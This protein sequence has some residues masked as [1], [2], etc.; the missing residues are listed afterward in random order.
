MEII[1]AK[2]SGF[3][4]GVKNALEQTYSAG[5]GSVTFGE[6]IHNKGVVEDLES[7]GIHAVNSVEECIG[8]KVIIRSHGVG[9]SMQ[10]ELADKAQE[11][12]DAT[13][14]FVKRIHDIVEK[15]YLMGYSIVIV[16]E[17]DHP[18]VIGTNGWC[19]DSA[20][21]ISD[22]SE[23]V[24]L[25]ENCVQPLCVVTQT[26]FSNAK[27]KNIELIIKNYNK[28]VEIFDTICYTT[29]DRQKEAAELAKKCDTV[30]VLGS[31]NSS[32]TRKLYEICKYY[33][34]RTY[35]ITNI[36]DL[37]QVAKNIQRLGITAGAS[38]P[39]ELI[40]EVVNTMSESQKINNEMTEF[41]Q[42]FE[43]SEDVV[44][45]ENKQYEVNV[46]SADETGIKCSF[47]GKKDAFIAKSEV[48]LD[49]ADY[50]PENYPAGMSFFAVVVKN[51]DKKAD[52]ISMSKRIIDKRIEE[53]K[54]CEEILTGTEFTVKI[55]KAVKGG[56]I[57]KLGSYTIFVPQSHVRM[58]FENNL[59]KYV[60]KEMRLCMIPGKS[61]LNPD[62]TE[63]EET[64][65][66]KIGKRVVASHRVI[67]EAEKQAKEDIFW[68]TMEVGGI[69]KG[70]VKRFTTFGAFV[71]VN[72]TDCL[73]HISDLS[74]VKVENPGDVLELNKTY[75]FLVLNADRESG[76]VSLGYK[77][78]QKKPYEEAQEKYP[79]GTIV[80]G[81]I[82]RI[83]NYG[84]FV[85]IDKGIDGL[86]PVS[87]ISY[88][89]VR[90]ANEAFAQGQEV[91]T[92]VI[93]FEGNKIT[94]SIKALLEPPVQQSIA[95][96]VITDDDMREANAQ[97]AKAN[98]KRFENAGGNQANKRNRTN[99]KIE[100][101][102]EVKQWTTET[103]N[104]TFADLF[105][106]LVFEVSDKEEVTDN[107]V[108]VDKE[109]VTAQE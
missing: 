54:K 23:A 81:T 29:R 57:A 14:P 42:L 30:L 78:L 33:C 87:E 75:D 51:S 6:L 91:E 84:A 18:E 106:N 45:K 98:I 83:F 69:V 95:D 66:K 65:E 107:E 24:Q 64:G 16:G 38:T 96:V 86:I 82:E 10:A 47:G 31:E 71:C 80:K 53:D 67:I 8:R 55:D 28:I 20:I 3:C 5:C 13:C 79:I 48:E 60:G 1:V 46:L 52:M 32:N 34:S 92:K 88:S 94:L 105:K 85:T 11:I 40:E 43:Q 39:G 37:S 93:K 15:Y 19:N 70:K 109:E 35:L 62:G 59:E 9:K 50:K 108:I 41:A 77:Q 7:K 26:T 58:G 76:K 2:S 49:E 72:G 56:L 44:I 97:R 63:V 17:K 89:Y 68:S 21:I 101:K 22:E 104:A 25:L 4:F 73:A 27:F 90:D 12:I 74:W 61:E 100:V 103:S 99:K 36:S 102:D